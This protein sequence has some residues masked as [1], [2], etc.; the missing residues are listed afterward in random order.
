MKKFM[1][2]VF[3]TSLFFS[4]AHTVKANYESE[5]KEKIDQA[6]EN[7]KMEKGIALDQELTYE[8]EKELAPIINSIKDADPELAAV[9]NQPQTRAVWQYSGH[10]FVTGD[11]K[12]YNIPHGH[13]GIGTATPQ[14]VI[15]ANPD[16]GVAMYRNRI[17]SYWSKVNSSI[18]GVRGASTANY[19]G[20][21]IYA[22]NQLGKGYSL[23]SDGTRTFYCSELVYYAWSNQGYNVGTMA[24]Y[25]LPWSI[26][27]NSNTYTVAKY[28]S[29]Y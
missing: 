25:I 22:N 16:K 19:G 28:G 10:I 9:K 12:T 27:N 11:A 7:Y 6:I 8:Q 3:V 15:E 26:Y 1:M 29:G 4:T 5:T 2:I 24:A 20:A 17:A 14:A 21:F 13:A 18:M 23:N